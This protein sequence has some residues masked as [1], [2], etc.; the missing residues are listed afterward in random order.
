MASAR[1]T[2]TTVRPTGAP[3]HDPRSV[4]EHAA[5][6]ARDWAEIQERMLVPLYEAVH[7]RLE[8]GPAT[9]VLGLG[10]RSGLA[11]LLAAGRGAQVAGLE[12]ESELRELA[13]GRRLR[14]GSGP[15]T[16]VAVARSA[17]SLVTVFEGL[18]GSA[19]PYRTVAE[20]ARLTLPGGH[21]VLAS[22]GP[23]ER[24]GSAAVLDVARRMARRST[25]RDPFELSP[26]GALEDLLAGTGLRPAGGG[27]VG[28]PFAYPDLDSAVRG[29]LST[30]LYDA[31][32]EFSGLPL[33]AKELE[34]AL[35][36]YLRP[37]G[38]VRMENVF[39]YLVA[40]R[41]R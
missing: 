28:C 2:G 9:S 37:D 34:E 27:R 12:P 40:E 22:W 23:R 29:L 25:A 11:L 26:P 24:C 36:P 1:V 38:T 32:A 6:R 10:C 3:P 31:A 35:H 7:D 21:V 19:D 13:R 15:R 16:A 33:V 8:V 30:G 4:A 20:A 41:P 14:V 39:R 5:A 18:P 17:Y